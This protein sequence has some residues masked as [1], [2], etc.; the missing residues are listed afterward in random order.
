MES[1]DRKPLAAIAAISALTA[2]LCCLPS[3]V[4]VLFAG[5]SA[6][7]AADELSNDLYYSWV[8]FALYA[9][10]LCMLAVGM[11]LYFRNR[12]I[13]TLDDAKRERRR[14][15]NTTMAVFTASVLGYLVWNFVILEVMG[16]ALGLPWEDSAFWDF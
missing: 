1:D 13:C 7:V 16:I 2:S 15:V 12:G 10:S 9:L 3:V 8:R 6:I 4:W 11:L 14:V 5:S